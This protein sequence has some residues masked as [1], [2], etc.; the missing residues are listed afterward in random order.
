[1]I[2][3]DLGALRAE[4]GGYV[5]SAD[6]RDL[7]QVVA[8]L[9]VER[10]LTIATAELG[11]GGLVAARLTEPEDS[12]R[13]FRGSSIPDTNPGHDGG[14]LAQA[15]AARQA[16]I[17]DIGVGVGPVI[18]PEDST[19][20]RPYGMVH[21]AVNLRGREICRQLSFNGDRARIREWAADAAL[22]LVRLSV[23]RQGAGDRDF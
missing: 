3:A 23:L 13:W 6:E 4:L 15:L 21:V 16:T 7:P 14:L 5:I 18:V 11:T 22:A 10:G 9:L 19:S 8:D 1:L 12:S 20:Q 2:E 17:A